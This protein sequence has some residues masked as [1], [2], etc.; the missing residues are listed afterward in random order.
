MACQF[1]D[2]CPS[3][4]GWCDGP[5]Q[6]FSRCVEFLVTAYEKETKQY[7]SAYYLRLRN[8]KEYQFGDRCICVKNLF[9]GLIQFLD[10]NYNLLAIVPAA[11][12]KA[13]YDKR[14]DE[15]LKKEEAE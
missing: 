5:K 4:S 14:T 13:I 11:D 2:K 10:K 7:E 3:Y 8:G 6:D 15:F 12:I 1:K 9:E